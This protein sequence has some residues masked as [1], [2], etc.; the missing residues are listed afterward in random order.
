VGWW[1][2]LV[3]AA[4]GLIQLSLGLVLFTKGSKTVPAAELALLALAEPMVAP[5]WVWLAFGEIPAAT[6]LLGGAV[7]LSA[8]VFQI[9]ATGRR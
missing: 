6:T 9:L 3:I 4:M 1:N 8:L 2:F 7:I 5:I